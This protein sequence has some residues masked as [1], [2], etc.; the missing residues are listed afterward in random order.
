[1]P[2]MPTSRS[3]A[4]GHGD[5]PAGPARA[6]LWGRNVRLVLLLLALWSALTLLPA[7]FARDLMFSFMGW[8]FSY[9]MAAYGAPLGYLAIIVAYARIMNGA[10]GDA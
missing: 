8:P 4:S 7:Y 5:G 10:D 9:W 3:S 2:H 1:M 6:P